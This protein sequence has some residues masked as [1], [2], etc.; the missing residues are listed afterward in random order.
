MSET[1]LMPLNGA[2]LISNPRKD[3]N[4][5]G[6]FGALALD[7]PNYDHRSNLFSRSKKSQSRTAKRAKLRAK[8]RKQDQ[9]WSQNKRLRAAYRKQAKA[10]GVDP[11]WLIGPN[12]MIRDRKWRKAHASSPARRRAL[13]E[14]KARY[15]QDGWKRNRNASGKLQAGWTKGKPYATRW[16]TKAGAYKTPSLKMVNSRGD[17]VVDV[18]ALR[19]RN[20][21]RMLDREL[22][23]G[24][25]TRAARGLPKRTSRKGRKRKASA[26]GRKTYTKKQS[27]AAAK[28]MGWGAF[29]KSMLKQGFTLQE[30]SAA[31][32]GQTLRNPRHPTNTAAKRRRANQ[33]HYGALALDN[34]IF[35][36]LALD[37]YG[38][39]AL[40][41]PMSVDGIKASVMKY[42]AQAAVGIAGA[43]VAIK[44]SPM[45]TEQVAKIPV[46][47]DFLLGMSIPA[48]IPGTEI[49]VPLLGGMSLAHTMSGVVTAVAL[50]GAVEALLRYGPSIPVLG[51]FLGYLAPYRTHIHALSGGLVIGG[52]YADYTSYAGGG[53]LGALA[54]DNEG[55]FGALALDNGYGDGMAY[56]LG[57]ISSDDADYSQASLADA[58][59][60][61]ADFD[62]AEGQAVLKGQTEFRRRYGRAPVRVASHG[63]QSAG[64][65]HLAGRT[66]HRWG[67]LVKMIG[68]SNVQRLAKLPPK[69][70]VHIIKGLRSNAI[71][72][73]KQLQIQ[74]E[75][76]QLASPE[77]TAAPSGPD[78][79][80]GA[81]SSFGSTIFAG[82]GL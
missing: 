69:E 53:D 79:V 50:S 31:Y 56:Q 36:A 40:D 51:D 64:P 32:K 22:H 66:G 21:A 7:N 44:V 20:S 30:A 61:G 62:L 72:T 82:Q 16:K 5:A 39:L 8:F 34:G 46:A 9:N 38:A 80:S 70:R 23:G 29:S 74:A 67:W 75:E 35:G 28:K 14:A 58:Y 41:N 10:A 68:W 37:N 81:Y 78:G 63:G 48:T 17:V 59:Y 55:I 49:E 71:T 42:G 4:M 26:K 25:R 2:L 77:L 76:A 27:A 33:K 3:Y 15:K 19:R 60:S 73:F 54:L 12:G 6:I 47:G 24:R 1:T 65:S 18:A 11:M 43:A 45:V 52:G 57:A 13:A